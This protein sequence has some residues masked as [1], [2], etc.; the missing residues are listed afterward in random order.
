[1]WE[2]YAPLSA[3]A[4][5]DQMKVLCALSVELRVVVS[6]LVLVLEIKF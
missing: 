6:L 1:M 3:G 2:R 4:C 5:R